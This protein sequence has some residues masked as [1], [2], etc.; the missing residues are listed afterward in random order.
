MV[1]QNQGNKLNSHES[2]QSSNDVTSADWA[3]RLFTGR[4]TKIVFAYFLTQWV[5]SSN[6]IPIYISWGSTLTESDLETF[7][8]VQANIPPES[9]FGVVTGK[10]PVLADPV[11]EWF[12]TLTQRTSINTP[13]GHEWLPETDFNQILISSDE[14]QDCAKQDINCLKEWEESNHIDIDYLY[15]RKIEPDNRG[16]YFPIKSPL[17]F[18]TIASGEYLAIYQTDEVSIFQKINGYIG[19]RQY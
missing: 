7:E 1:A 9:Q 4:V 2:V 12:P 3:E 19:K 5:F 17:E 11:I 16:E 14:F 6:A 8:W 18:S 13:Q 15:I 10:K